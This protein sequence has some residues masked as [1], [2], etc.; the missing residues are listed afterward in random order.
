MSDDIFANGGSECKRITR[1]LVGT[2]SNRNLAV[3]D[4][5]G[6][7]NIGHVKERRGRQKVIG[8]GNLSKT[9]VVGRPTMYLL[10]NT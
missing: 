9:V 5:S 2:E 3:Q 1:I 6:K 7:G 10:R 4:Q 8:Y